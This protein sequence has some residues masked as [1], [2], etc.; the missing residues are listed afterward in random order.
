MK[1]LNI[2]LNL[3]YYP[4]LKE[5]LLSKNIERINQNKENWQEPFFTDTTSY[6]DLEKIRNISA[7]FNKEDIRNVIILGTGGSIQTFLALSHLTKKCV[8]PITS[9]R[10]IELGY[11]L[12]NT[13]PY[14]S[15]V[16]PI[17]RSGE[18]L[19]INST[20]GIFIE[21]GYKFLGLSS[22]G[23]MNELLRKISAPIMEVP[24]LSGRFAASITNVA[25]VPAFIS[26]IDIKSFLEGLKQG[27]DEFMTFSNNLSLEFA[28]FIYQLYIKG[29]KVVFSMP[30]SKN[31]EGS[32]GLLVQDISESTGK[33]KKGLMGAYQE[34][35][36]SQHS[37][38]EYILGG[39]KGTVIPII[40]TLENEFGDLTLK[41]SI[42]NINGKS[43][44]TVINYQ[45]DATFQ[46]MIDQEVPCAKISLKDPS[47]KNIGN[48]ISFIQSTVY[49]L[50]LLLD[51][52]WSN[53]P[54]VN[55]GK[56]IC[57]KA[58][59]ENLSEQKRKKNRQEL[60]KKKFQNFY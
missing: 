35:P 42:E 58:L 48:L 16:I 50:C 51:V 60:A 27:Y 2:G 37:V 23:K 22:R 46:A 44:Q 12:E 32:M 38:L 9:S 10:A 7:E 40:F 55:I 56:E 24:D 36:L 21:K 31:L 57:N 26:G 19:D 5:R 39:T 8:F 17:S 54:K 13:T 4:K 1:K 52:N 6:L 29:Y 25:L 20:I 11:C 41:S 47:E 15:I 59:K 3:E 30:Y 28:S 45:A 49:Y 14:D 43:A 33:E 53:N 34:S 18:T